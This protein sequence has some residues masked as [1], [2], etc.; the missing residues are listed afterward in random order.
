MKNN[1]IK[2]PK[3]KGE[4]VLMTANTSVWKKLKKDKWLY[5][6]A[7]PGILYF[8]IFR[9][10][11]MFGIVVAFQ[12][13]N[14]F[15]G[16]WKSPWVGFEHFKTLF[17]DPD[18]PMLFRNTLLIS[19]YNILFYFPVPIIL[20]L[21]I[22]EVRNQVYKRIVQTCVYVPHFVS[23]V[24]IASIT[25]VLLSSETGV[26]N[27]ILYSLTGK[28]IEFLT[29][30]RWFRPLII[31]Q[32]IW[33]EAGWGTIIF[34]A[35]LSNVDPTLYE[36]AIV[37]GATRWQQTWHITIPSIMSTVIILFI[38]RLG[39]LLDTGFEQIFLM[40]NPINRSVAEVFDTYV[41]Q[42]GVTQG[43]YSYSTAVGLFKSVVGLILI[44]VS[45]YLSKKFTET[46]LF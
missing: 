9:Y 21:L 40:K 3:K 41:Y 25:Y 33:K 35:A 43:A 27:N 19:F 30:P 26:I 4:N 16:F 7:L 42:I 6:L 12:D 38:L 28:K 14:P 46:S 44:Q 18:F 11:P 36:A 15:L 5:I 45:N 10:I 29:D 20:A 37:D 17:T 2:G 1:I 31:I 32:S 39:H 13:F 22:N 34:L 23:M 24:V 8:I